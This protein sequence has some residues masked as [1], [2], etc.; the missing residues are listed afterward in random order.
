ML[1]IELQN[2]T[3]FDCFVKAFHYLTQHLSREELYEPFLVEAATDALEVVRQQLELLSSCVDE[4]TRDGAKINRTFDPSSVMGGVINTSPL[5]VIQ[6]E[7]DSYPCLLAMCGSGIGM[8]QVN[9]DGTYNLIYGS[10]IGGRAFHGLGTLL[11]GCETFEELLELAEAGDASKVDV[12]SNDLFVAAQTADGD[13]SLYAK[14]VAM[15]P[16]LVYCFGKGVGAKLSDFSREDVARSVLNMVALNLVDTIMLNCY[17]N[18]MKKIYMCGSFVQ[19]KTVRSLVT[20]LTASRIVSAVST[21]KPFVT[22]DFVKSGSH[23]GAL[24]ALLYQID[25]FGDCGLASSAN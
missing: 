13:D 25:K 20:A 22:L 11:T 24:G 2:V 12:Y 16:S 4:N 23:L 19:S 3:E 8:M 15:K 6:S 14:S 18:G 7:P 9:A 17:A 1:N 5:P 21:G 10:H